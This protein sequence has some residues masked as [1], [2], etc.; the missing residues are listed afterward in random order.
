M[1]G[2][3]KELHEIAKFK[4]KMYFLYDEHIR[5]FMETKHPSARWDDSDELIMQEL[6][7]N[8]PEEFI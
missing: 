7:E 8:F 6:K 1:I 4:Q 3:R 5:V 2:S